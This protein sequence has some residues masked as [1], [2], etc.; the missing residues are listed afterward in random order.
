ML[1]NTADR[2][3]WH[4]M[5]VGLLFF[6]NNGVLKQDMSPFLSQSLY[7]LISDRVSGVVFYFLSRNFGDFGLLSLKI[8]AFFRGGFF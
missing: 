7:G 5:A 4:R 6:Q 2:D 1:E 8:L 3:L